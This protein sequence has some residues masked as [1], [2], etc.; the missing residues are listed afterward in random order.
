MLKMKCGQITKV[1]VWEKDCLKEE[2]ELNITFG[3]GHVY[4]GDHS[5]SVPHGKCAFF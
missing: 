2:C 5:N 4:N 1:G 3:D